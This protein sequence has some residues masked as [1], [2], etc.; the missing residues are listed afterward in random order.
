[1]TTDQLPPNIRFA[2]NMIG[3]A[4][5]SSWGLGFEI[6]T[7]PERSWVPGSV[8]SFRWSGLWG[9]YF[10][11]DPA[12]RLIAVQRIQ[13]APGKAGPAFSAIR[14]LVYGA[15][16]VPPPNF[17]APGSPPSV[18]ADTLAEYAGKYAFGPST[19]PTTGTLPSTLE[20]AASARISR[21]RKAACGSPVRSTV[22]RRR[23]PDWSQ[24]TSSPMWTTPRWQASGS[25]K[26]ETSCE[27]IQAL[28]FD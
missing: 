19:S 15:L 2:G 24:A 21:W 10:W 22:L 14:R 16:R 8:G 12:E 9:T 11:V 27:A 7:D 13:A 1:M 28:R 25:I 17:S 6:R 4:F 5:G 3:P 18:G 26:L 23:A 20:R